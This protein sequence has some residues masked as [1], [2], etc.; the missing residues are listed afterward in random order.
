MGILIAPHWETVSAPMRQL[1]TWVGQQ[2]F[3]A[4]FY[5]AGGTALAL[6]MGHRKSIDLDFFSETDQVHTLTRQE[7]IRIFGHHGGQVLESTDGNLVFLV[8]EVRI[9]FFS[10]GYC[11]LEPFCQV[12]QV[13]LASWL[14]IGLMKLDAVIGRGSRKDFYDLYVLSRQLPLA[15]LL[16]AGQ[17]KYPTVRD[18]ALMAVESLVLFE[19]AERDY[20]P[21]L[22]IQVPWEQVRGY[23][24]EQGKLLG[25]IWFE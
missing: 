18:F 24:V 1:L 21:E 20:Q 4:R 7:L 22:L 15:T 16:E 12:E 5:L 11:L 25:K 6:Q 14:D 2:E 9:G 23:F 13:N 19:N 3:A 17:R 8:D 10:Y